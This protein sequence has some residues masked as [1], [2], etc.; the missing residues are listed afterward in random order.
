M[1]IM[2]QIHKKKH[3]FE[4]KVNILTCFPGV[5]RLLLLLRKIFNTILFTNKEIHTKKQM[6]NF[7]FVLIS[8]R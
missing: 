5:A 7:T 2:R 8:L 3:L 1:Q 6:T 4:T